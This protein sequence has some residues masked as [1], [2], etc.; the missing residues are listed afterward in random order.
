[1]RIMIDSADGDKIRVN[2]PFTLIQ[3][4]LDMGLEVMQFSG[5][6]A[7]KNVNFGQIME[8]VQQGTVG[9]LVDIESADGD[10]VRL[11]VE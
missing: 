9:N 11:L 1:M 3:S 6:D 4:V 5:I 10:I 8:L 7:L 2:V